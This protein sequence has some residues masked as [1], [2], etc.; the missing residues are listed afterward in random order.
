MLEKVVGV[1]KKIEN[2]SRSKKNI[3]LLMRKTIAEAVS[4]LSYLRIEMQV[5]GTYLNHFEYHLRDRIE[6]QLKES[7]GEDC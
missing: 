4:E 5:S 7:I 1:L 6:K 2:I 3:F